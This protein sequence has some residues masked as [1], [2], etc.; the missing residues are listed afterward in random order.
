MPKFTVKIEGRNFFGRHTSTAIDQKY[1][2]I[3]IVLVEAHDHIQAEQKAV[4]ILKADE[5]LRTFAKN[6]SEDPPILNIEEIIEVSEW[7]SIAHPK[8]GLVW[9]P[10]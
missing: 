2:F 7:P 3:T 10:E 5:D 9:F 1:G 8:S 6:D 4:S